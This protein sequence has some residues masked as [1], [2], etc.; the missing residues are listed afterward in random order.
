MLKVLNVTPES[1]PSTLQGC[2]FPNGCHS[3]HSAPICR[4]SPVILFT[5]P[6]PRPSR[7]SLIPL[8]T[9][10]PLVLLH[11]R[12]FL[13][14]APL[15]DLTSSV[16]LFQV[17]WIPWFKE[18]L[19]P[20]LRYISFTLNWMYTLN[21]SN[22]I[23]YRNILKQWKQKENLNELSLVCNLALFHLALSR[24]LT[25]LLLRI[26]LILFLVY[27]FTYFKI[28]FSLSNYSLGPGLVTDISG[29]SRFSDRTN[30]DITTSVSVCV[31]IGGGGRIC[32][33]LGM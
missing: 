32:T 5:P 12:V 22:A 8:S 13:F 26:K 33:G 31:C 28:L 4:P 21:R 25:V 20:L 3:A 27:I 19:S 18:L 16:F 29:R 2:R 9:F 6:P 17:R 7:L 10:I 24:S 11:N 1:P 14:V 23:I 15:G 30:F